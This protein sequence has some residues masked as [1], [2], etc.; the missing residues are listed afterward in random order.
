MPENFDRLS[1]SELV[2]NKVE[3]ANSNLVSDAWNWVDNHKVETAAVVVGTAAL[4]FGGSKFLG[5]FLKGSEEVGTQLGGGLTS[6]AFER[7]LAQS[8]PAAS[9]LAT[10]FTADAAELASG[11]LALTGSESLETMAARGMA[12]KLSGTAE[13]GLAAEMKLASGGEV[14]AEKAMTGLADT[15]MKRL[16]MS[17]G[18]ISGDIGKVQV[19][20]LITP[21]N[22]EGMWWGALD[23]VIERNAGGQFHAQ[24]AAAM[25]LVDGQVVVAAKTAAHRGAFDNVVFVVDDLR[26]PLRDV[27][28]NGLQAA[29]KAG[30]QSV[31]LPALRTGVMAGK[32]E[33]TVQ[34]T[35]DE[36]A[37][38][39][40]SFME[41][42]PKSLKDIKFVVYNNDEILSKLTAALAK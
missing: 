20:A 26:A 33:K 40:K 31:S 14:A 39:V 10:R 4:A 37:A 7:A 24:A 15:T 11:R 2:G 18:A 36:M 13:T 41:T 17:T 9:R 34:Q 3:A 28:F 1:K 8:S 19:D 35:V 29:E 16:G 6:S 25:P 12:A 5:S 30:Y 22:S 38:G 42:G 23:G 21:I 32:V 27:V